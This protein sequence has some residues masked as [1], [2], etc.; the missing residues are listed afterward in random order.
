MS[1]R[2]KFA[3]VSGLILA[4]ALMAPAAHPSTY[5]PPV[6]GPAVRLPGTDGFNEPR[7]IVDEAGREWAIANAADF[8]TLFFRS[9]DHGRTFTRTPDPPQRNATPDVDVVRTRTGRLIASELDGG[10]T[11]FDIR[12]V[13]AYSDD[14]GAT[15]HESAGMVAADTDRQW[16]AVGPDDPTTHLPRVYLLFHN[17]FTGPVVHGMFVQTSV[18]NG[19]TFGDPVLVTPVGDPALLDLQCADSGGPSSISVDPRTGRLYVVFGTRSSPVGGCGATVTEGAE[20][21][22]VRAT[23]VWVA[24]SPDGSD[25]SWRT[26]LAVNHSDDHKVVGLQLS[27]GAL[28]DDGNVYVAY[29]ESRSADD[30]TSSV[31]LT[32]APPDLSSWSAPVTVAPIGAGHALVHVVAGERGRVALAYFEAQPQPSGDPL[33]YSTIAT[34][35]NALD[36]APTFEAQRLADAPA[37]KGTVGAMEGR[38]LEDE[39]QTPVNGVIEGLFCGRFSD[40]YGITTDA[41]GRIVVAWPGQ[42]KTPGVLAGAY[43]SSQIGGSALRGPLLVAG[44]SETGASRTPVGTIPATGGNANG[45]VPLLVLGMALAA[46]VAARRVSGAST[47]ARAAPIPPGPTAPGRRC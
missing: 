2:T 40:V 37:F 39:E 11:G 41:A 10:A 16:L 25:G 45:T 1:A 20:I 34:S 26:S 28:D 9:D 33:W 24:T 15:W 35:F 7:V 32:H 46:V 23:R 22:I 12:F 21:N 5:A 3:L 27:Y 29:P 8:H 19:A 47:S 6:F 13:T 36:P 38:C 31:M 42:A 44:A 43:V 18:D 17:L 30:L 4:L 14:N